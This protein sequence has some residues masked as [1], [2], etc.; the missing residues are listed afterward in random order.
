MFDHHTHD[1]K[2]AC[3]NGV[4]FGGDGSTQLAVS[5]DCQAVST[6]F[7]I[8]NAK[9][10]VDASLNPANAIQLQCLNGASLGGNGS[11]VATSASSCS[12]L[13]TYWT[14]P[15]GAYYVNS[16]IKCVHYCIFVVFN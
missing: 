14:R 5:S 8:T 2:L 4:S 13:F 9:V 11:S 6:Y 16:A 12:A 10:Y 7:S 1:T 3:I 15:A